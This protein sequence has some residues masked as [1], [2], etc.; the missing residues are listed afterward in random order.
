LPLGFSWGAWD[1]SLIE[2]H[3]EVKFASFQGEIDS[4][5]FPSLADRNGCYYLMNEIRKKQGFLPEATWL[6]SGPDGPC[7]TV[8]GLRDRIGLGAIQNLGVTPAYRGRGLGAALLLK[9]LAGFRAAGIDYAYLE[10]TAQNDGAVRLYRRLGFRCR[11]TIYKAV[12]AASFPFSP[13][14]QPAWNEPY[15]R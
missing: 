5:V 10:V 8:Q 13:A 12:D 4:S 1:D 9:A 15:R 6:V 11:K 14:A 7:G 2:A 3:A